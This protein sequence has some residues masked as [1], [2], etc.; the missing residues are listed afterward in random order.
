MMM[1]GPKTV[2]LTGGSEGIGYEACRQLATLPGCEKIVLTSRSEARATA[3]TEALAKLTGKPLTLFGVC[4]L[5]NNSPKS[6]KAAVAAMPTGIDALILNASAPPP[7]PISK[8]STER[9]GVAECMQGTCVGNLELLEGLI[10]AKKLSKG[11]RVI[12][13]GSELTRKTWLFTGLQ[14]SVV[15]NKGKIAAH[16]SSPPSDCVPIRSSFAAYSTAKLIATLAISGLAKEHPDFYFATVSP[17]GVATN[18]YKQLPQ[19]MS[20]LMLHC[21]CMFVAFR[22]A[23]SVEEGAK[24]Y[25]DAVA[26]DDFP[27]VFPSGAVLASPSS[28]CPF[29]LGA[30]GPLADQAPLSRRFED[31]ELQKEAV[32][33]MRQV[34]A[35]D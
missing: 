15:L 18:L 16:V 12:F 23:H 11:C 7:M 35:R 9:A 29:W 24:R 33:V 17:G 30:A 5:D 3:A 27:S 8:M 21:S 10:A 19:P 4:A 22:A 20:G 26:R 28:C 2:V 6:I 31:T 14:P 25:V 32:A 34:M 13:S 1:R